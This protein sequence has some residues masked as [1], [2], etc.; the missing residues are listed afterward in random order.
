LT[1]NTLPPAFTAPATASVAENGSLVFSTTNSNAIS[2][3]DANAGS[4]IEQLTLTSTNGTLKLGATFGI[5]F[6]SGANKSASM[7]ISGTLA[8]L[9]HALK[10]L[11]FTPTSGYTGSASIALSYTDVGN[12]LTASANIAI[13]VGTGAAVSSGGSTTSPQTAVVTSSASP[14]SSGPE[15]SDIDTQWAGFAAALQTLNS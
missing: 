1:V 7:T 5:T 13:T 15:T 14:G 4:A 10:N 3:A 8:N 9:N 2:V 11:T 6:I 12:S